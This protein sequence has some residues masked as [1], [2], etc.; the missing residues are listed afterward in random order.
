[1]TE[2]AGGWSLQFSYSFERYFNAGLSVN[3]DDADL[4]GVVLW[5]DGDLRLEK[6]QR[7]RMRDLV[8]GLRHRPAPVDD[9]DDAGGR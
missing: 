3:L 4:H 6:W 5:F 2:D 7:G 1:V 8:S 9:A